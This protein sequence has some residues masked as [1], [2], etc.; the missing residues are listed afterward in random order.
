MENFG[1]ELEQYRSDLFK[2]E[3]LS[4]V[5]AFPA[6]G[7]CFRESAKMTSVSRWLPRQRATNSRL[8]KLS[9]TST[10]WSRPKPRRMTPKGQNRIQTSFRPRSP[11][12]GD[13]RPDN[14][15]VVGDTAY[16]AEAAGKAH[17]RTIGSCVGAG[18][19]KTCAKPDASRFTAIPRICSTDT[20]RLR[21]AEVYRG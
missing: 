13:V 12:L 8:I 3:F 9:L 15:V 11:E 6:F 10:I 20:M 14:V 1:D 2:K 18:A 21:L 4:R 16:D 7:N 17:L 5:K 19:R